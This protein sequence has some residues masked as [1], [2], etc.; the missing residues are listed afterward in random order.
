MK[1]SD[2]GKGDKRRNAQVPDHVVEDNWNTIFKRSRID[3][4]GQNGNDGIV[5][6][7]DD[8]ISHSGVGIPHDGTHFDTWRTDQDPK[9]NGGNN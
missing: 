4:I 6:D 8:Y 3:I 9:N 2:G 5:Y 1:S 7:S